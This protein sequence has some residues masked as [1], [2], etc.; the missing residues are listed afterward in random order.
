[1]APTETVRRRAA[2]D[3]PPRQPMTFELPQLPFSKDALG[4]HMSAETLEY[5]H[6]KHHKAYVDKLNAGIQGTQWE[7][8]SL[9]DIVKGADGGIFNNGA[10]HWNHSFFWNCLSPEGGGQPSGALNDAIAKKWGSFDAFKKEFSDQSATL[11]GSG[12]AWLVKDGAGL[13]IVQKSN[14]GNPLRDGQAP[15]LT[16]D[17]WEHAYYIDYRNARPKFIEAFWNMVNWKFAAE[18]FGK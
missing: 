2:P 17:V 14:A 6:G 15:V 1:M 4:P 10:Q 3:Q 11:F 16:L 7:G 18:Q 8:K 9:E 13:A 5:H 12:W